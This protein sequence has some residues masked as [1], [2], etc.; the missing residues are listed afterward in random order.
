[1]QRLIAF[2]LTQRV[3]VFV[4]VAAL[5]GFGGYA[6]S[7]LPI[8]A[9][10]DVQ[11]VQVRVISQRTGAAPQD[12]E[13][14]VTLPIERE[15]AGIPRLSNV[16]SVTMTGLSIVT[17]TFADGT[18]DY[19]ARQQVL[20]KLS[21]VDLP[22]GVQPQLA[23]LSTAVGEIYRYTLEAPGLSEV[24]ARTLQDWT[25][26]PFL[27]MT[28]GV[29]DI[30][31]FGGALKEFQI[32]VDPVALRKYQVTL[33]QL[34]QAVSNAN[35]SAG[36]GLMRRGDTSLVVRASGL[37][38]S[39]ADIRA[40]VVA[41]RQGRPVTVADLA[42]VREGE[43]PRLGI[44]AAGQRDS[45]VE[46]IVSMTKGGDPAKI[47]AELRERIAQIE[48]R[49][50]AGVKIVP[51]Y[52]R[53]QL[54]HH[55]VATVVENLV[56]GA[57]LVVAVLVV[58]LSSWRA[59]LVVA[60]VIPL[61][62]L[63]AFILIT[64]RG[65]SANLISLGAVDFGIIIDSAVVIV[66]A[67]MVR[68]AAKTAL[69]AD[70]PEA[71][72]QR[73]G[74]L[75]HTVSDLAHPV[76]FSKAIIILAFVPIFTFQRVEGKIFTP[77]A[78]TLSFALLGAVLLTFTH[79]PALLATVLQRRTLAEKHKPW[80]GLAAGALPR[81]A[82]R[83]HAPRR[84]HAVARGAA[85]GTR[86]GTGTAAGQRVP[87]QA[88]RGQHLADHHAAD[89][90]RARDHQ[91]GGTQRARHPADVSRGGAADQPGR[92]ARR[93]LRPEGAEQPRD[94]GRSA[95]A[96]GLALRGQGGADRRHVGQAGRHPR[97]QHQF[98]AGNPG[99]RRGVAIG[100]S[101]R[102]RREGDRQQPRHPRRARRKGGHHFARH[103]RCHRRGQH[104]YRRAERAGRHA[105][106]RA[107]RALRPH[108]QRRGQRHRPVDVGQLDHQLLRRRPPLRRG[109]AAR[110]A[111]PRQRGRGARTAARRGRHAGR[112]RP[113]H[114]L[115][116]RGRERRGAPGRLAHLPRVGLAHGHRQGQP[117]GP[118]PGQLRG[119]GPAHRGAPGRAAAGLPAGVGRSVRELAAGRGAARG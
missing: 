87:A 5:V 45:I 95:A 91:A 13:R 8:E 96:L 16:R 26:R 64:A 82:R 10:P 117:A 73:L 79:L 70:T 32:E 2:A 78:L 51:I 98:L 83:D 43:R 107:A 97:H 57:L 86:A 100:L 61:A 28:P 37:F 77:V 19:F 111:A 110:P 118:R 53:T 102:D 14:S 80:A 23:P 76:L 60:T 67:L 74:V 63:F 54:V 112:Q 94:P 68:L 88:R 92:P 40:A 9:F 85:R 106:P 1:M 69:D 25:V 71:R 38:D 41:S 4:L 7:N 56:V 6:A 36:G 50:P 12:M 17:L 27:R 29:A 116:G 101:R 93:R 24:E 30:V 72:H 113:G 89:L 103:S 52:D 34:G 114:H 3:F 21:T 109:G 62:L 115:A 55:T 49:L 66:E 42:Q 18:D 39:L 75:H 20:E 99:Q 31:T 44:A 58:F 11:D 84:P 47:N 22:T 90:G 46:G 15:V 105:R 33:D 35:G 48:P 119:R 65:V 104:A 108:G 59:A 81:P